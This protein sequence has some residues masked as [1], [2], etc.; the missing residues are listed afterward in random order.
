MQKVKE[1]P[2]TGTTNGATMTTTTTTTNNDSD[3]RLKPAT[4]MLPKPAPIAA[5]PQPTAAA[6]TA[7]ASMF[8]GFPGGFNAAAFAKAAAAAFPAG[9]PKLAAAPPPPVMPSQAF[10]VAPTAASSTDKP[11]TKRRKRGRAAEEG[12]VEAP[13]VPV[14][15]VKPEGEAAVTAAAAGGC[16][17]QVSTA[18]GPLAAAEQ[19]VAAGVA[20]S[21]QPEG[22]SAKGAWPSPAAGGAGGAGGTTI[23]V[24]TPNLLNGDMSNQERKVCCNDSSSLA[25]NSRDGKTSVLHRVFFRVEAKTQ[26]FTLTPPASTSEF[27]LKGV[28]LGRLLLCFAQDPASLVLVG[29]A[30][31]IVCT[32]R[33]LPTNLQVCWNCLQYSRCSSHRSTYWYDSAQHIIPTGQCNK[34]SICHMSALRCQRARIFPVG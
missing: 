5:L 4:T 20:I 12:D 31:L 28:F 24:L 22:T 19:P 34:L 21:P 27:Q 8:A 10:G 6:A 30:P 25:L 29:R 3:V 26:I 2:G 23:S 9:L 18:G 14:D 16:S 7:M 11:A 17:P 32:R 1:E 13:P 15:S 33:A